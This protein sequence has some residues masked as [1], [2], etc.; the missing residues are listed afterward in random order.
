MLAND[1]AKHFHVGMDGKPCQ[2]TPDGRRRVRRG[3]SRRCPCHNVAHHKCPEAKP[4]IGRCGRLTTAFET[5]ACGYCVHCAGDSR[6][7]RLE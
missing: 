5:A 2:C 4:C 1:N 6:W 7:R 3:C